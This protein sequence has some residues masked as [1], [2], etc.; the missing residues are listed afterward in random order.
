M[1]ET[2]GALLLE[3][4]DAAA[5]GACAQEQW[6]DHCA[7]SESCTAMVPSPLASDNDQHVECAVRLLDLVPF[8][9]EREGRLS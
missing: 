2:C 6:C 8:L 9:C 3:T 7:P 5:A 4:R 1:E